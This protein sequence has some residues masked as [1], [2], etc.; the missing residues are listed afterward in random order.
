L[1]PPLAGIDIDQ[2]GAS[3]KGKTKNAM[4]NMVKELAGEA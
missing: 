4:Y 1:F 3:K 2:P